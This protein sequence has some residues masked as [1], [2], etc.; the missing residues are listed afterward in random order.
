MKKNINKKVL[1][2]S[3]G[4]LA[5]FRKHGN[6]G[7]PEGRRL[8][9]LRS[10]KTHKLK[11]S[12]FI[13][14]KKIIIPRRSSN[15]AELLGILIGDGHLSRYQV[16][17]TTNSDTDS[18]HAQY[19]SL[20]FNKLFSINTL[21]KKRKNKK[22]VD[23]I[24]SSANLVRYLNKL[25][26]PIGNKL[27]I[28]LKVPLWIKRNRS[29]SRAFIRGLFDTDGCVFI[30][31]HKYKDRTYRYLG[32]TFTSYDDKFLNEIKELLVNFGF[33][34]TLTSKQRSVYLRKQSEIKEY[35]DL[36]GTSNLKH[37]SRFLRI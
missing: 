22:A 3:L 34:P 1:A 36:I 35:F 28:G 2:G 20:L 37:K 7:T 26:M 6:F 11:P 31:T 18:E 27:T 30:D 8:G 24:V 19:V 10:L 12:G 21:I 17:F 5:R 16:L 9:G 33:N 4:G 14:L 13:Q 29:F 25:G 32:W 23:I 15:L